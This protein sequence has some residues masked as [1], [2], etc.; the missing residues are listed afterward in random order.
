MT[1]DRQDHP[2]AGLRNDIELVSVILF[3]AFNLT[4]VKVGLREIQPLAYNLIR[5]VSA[6]I[7]LLLLTRLR[8]GPIRVRR[9]DVG[10]MI[11]L[12]VIGHTAYQICFIVG[13]AHTTAS[14]AALLFGSSPVVVAILSRIAGHERI[15]LTGAGG[16]L[17]GFYGVYLIVGGGGDI[18]GPAGS[19]LLGNVLIVGG[20][21][22]WALYTVLARRMLQHYSP[23]R[24][25]SVS[26]SIGTILLIPPALPQTLR[27][28]WGAVSGMT[29]AG[30]AYS[31]LF[32]LVI[33]YVIWYRSV[34]KVGNLKTAVYSNL[35]PVFGTLFSVWLLHE[36]LTAGLW[37]GAACILA[38]I[39]LTR[40]SGRRGG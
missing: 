19:S 6:S 34:K 32:A 39:I 33:S 40:V 2:G 38:G 25:T 16:A 15:S 17:L 4:V 10:R 36:Q 29:W 18:P 20:V 3:W 11:L 31:I 28:D 24:V 14:S 37:L 12:G 26:L 7:I 5:F 9:E 27:Q 8:E 1:G 35:V 21:V 30:L 13:L 23:L 22:C